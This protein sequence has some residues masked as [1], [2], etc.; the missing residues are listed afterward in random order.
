MAGALRP[1]ERTHALATAALGDATFERLMAEGR[2]LRDEQ[3][4]ALAF[5]SEDSV[6]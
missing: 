6:E 1:W 3:I 2:G 4:E 5:A